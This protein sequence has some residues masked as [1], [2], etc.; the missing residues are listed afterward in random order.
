ML[1]QGSIDRRKKTFRCERRKCHFGLANFLTL[2]VV[3]D[4]LNFKGKNATTTATKSIMRSLS[5]ASFVN[6]SLVVVVA[7]TLCVARTSATVKLQF[8]FLVFSWRFDDNFRSIEKWTKVHFLLLLESTE[9]TMCDTSVY[10]SNGRKRRRKIPQ[11]KTINN[12]R[13]NHYRFADNRRKK[14]KEEKK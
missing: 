13:N 12:N 3:C 14:I 10:E 8:P 4:N 2:S 6:K 11:K 5:F 1:W 7:P 9:P